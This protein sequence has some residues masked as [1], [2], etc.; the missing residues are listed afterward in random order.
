[1]AAS[2]M[3]LGLVKFGKVA[4]PTWGSMSHLPCFLLTA[5]GFGN[6]EKSPEILAIQSSWAPLISD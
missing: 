3:Y 2:C 6:Y 4:R 1:M 5:E